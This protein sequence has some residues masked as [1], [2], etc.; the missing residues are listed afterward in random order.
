M[1]L[2]IGHPPCL[3]L[4]RQGISEKY[5]CGYIGWPRSLKNLPL[6]TPVPSPAIVLLC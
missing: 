3:V 4:L 6:L 1:W 2:L 5:S